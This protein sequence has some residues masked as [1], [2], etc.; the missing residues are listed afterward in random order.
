MSNRKYFP[1]NC[2]SVFYG[3]YNPEFKGVLIWL[4]SSYT[5]RDAKNIHRSPRDFEAECSVYMKGSC[6]KRKKKEKEVVKIKTTHKLKKIIGFHL[7]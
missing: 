7:K 1:L 3:Q 6:K 2:V 4:L 5:R